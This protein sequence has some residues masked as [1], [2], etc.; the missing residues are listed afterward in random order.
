MATAEADTSGGEQGC[1]QGR[2]G[3][4]SCKTCVSMA[5]DAMRDL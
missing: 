3:G 4:G 2:A 5:P 1:Y